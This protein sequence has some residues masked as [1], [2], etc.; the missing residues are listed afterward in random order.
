[1]LCD[2]SNSKLRIWRNFVTFVSAIVDVILLGLAICAIC[3]ICDYMAQFVQPE[4][5]APAFEAASSS[6]Y[7]H[8][9]SDVRG[10]SGASAGAAAPNGPAPVPPADNEL[11]SAIVAAI[12]S[13]LVAWPISLFVS[14]RTARREYEYGRS[15]YTT[16][17]RFDREVSSIRKL[18]RVLH[19]M[20]ECLQSASANISTKADRRAF[21]KTWDLLY[22]RAVRALGESAP[23]LS[24]LDD[25]VCG[26]CCG[27]LDAYGLVDEHD[28]E[29]KSLYEDAKLLM[30]RYQGV[31]K[32][33]RAGG[34]VPPGAAI[35]TSYDTFARC[36]WCR[37]SSIELGKADRRRIEFVNSLFLHRI[38]NYVLGKFNR[39][40]CP[41]R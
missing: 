8:G 29:R 6:G 17:A 20:M 19:E 1:M 12:A 18:S 11:P 28:R 10:V 4:S 27:G 40:R 15:E 39:T 37:L 14:R 22:S 34:A 7:V 36:A 3:G 2:S 21:D 5:A 16:R 24:Y 41:Y 30:R 31:V 38:A 13:I 23:F 25:E 35:E 9:E 32:T 33:V 26:C